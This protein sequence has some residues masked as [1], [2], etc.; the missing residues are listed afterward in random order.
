MIG[1]TFSQSHYDKY[2]ET[3]RQNL[4]EEIIDKMMVDSYLP[5]K[6]KEK[7]FKLPLEKKRR[8]IFAYIDENSGSVL[9]VID[10][11]DKDT[12]LVGKFKVIL[13]ALKRYIEVGKQEVRKFGEVFTPLILVEIM[14]NFLPKDV[15][16]NPNLKWL[17]PASGMGNFPLMVIKRLMVGLKD[18]E[19]DPEKRYKHIVENMIYVSE[20]QPR[21]AFMYL[22]MVDPHDEYDINL[23]CGSS[24]D[25][26][27][28]IHMRDVWELESFDIVIGNPPYSKG[29]WVKFMS[30]FLPMMNYTGVLIS[31]D[32]TKNRSK[33]SD[34]I[35]EMLQRN[36]IQSITDHTEHFNVESGTLVT[37][38]FNNKL[39]VKESAHVIDNMEN[40]I[41]NKVINSNLPKM[42]SKLSNNR[43]KIFNS[44]EKMDNVTDT[45]TSKFVENIRKDEIIFK[46]LDINN[47][48]NKNIKTFDL[49]KWFVTNRYLG[50]S[51]AP[52]I[53]NIDNFISVY[54]SKLFRFI[55]NI[56][57]NGMFDTSPRHINLLPQMNISNKWTDEKLYEY[58]DLT[59]DEIKL[60]E[61]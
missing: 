60:I 1:A 37:Y 29:L 40:R 30:K 17:D 18:W 27:L 59:E 2:E 21:N 58:F 55:L 36:N 5:E 35:I 46:Y 4:F 11:M 33:V 43:S 53:Y 10:D 9:K 22:Y 25:M 52:S 8:M 13:K 34:N 24:L 28:N 51:E 3:K 12:P 41:V 50:K 38:Y 44:Q 56:L 39:P 14:L 26:G 20:L 7:I 19:I 54:A 49:N 47:P 48:L 61:G 6:F 32:G 16:T 23:Y 45:F 31:P 57:R 42:V 15:W